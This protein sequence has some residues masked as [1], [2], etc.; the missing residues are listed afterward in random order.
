MPKYQIEVPG[1]G[2]FEV[3]SPTD[4]SDD[5]AYRAVLGQINATPAVKPDTGFTGALKAGKENIL[6]D[7]ERFKGKTGIKDINEAEAAAKAHEV[8]AGQVFKPTEEGWTEA[9]FTKFKETLGGSL[10]YMAAPI[11]AGIGAATLP[12]TGTAATVAGLGLTGLTSAAQFT[13]SNLSRK[14]KEGQ[15]LEEASLLEAGAAAVPQAALDIIGLRMI[16]GIRGIFGKAGIEITEEQAAKLAQRSLL[17]KAGSVALTTGKTMG[18]E[19]LTET[20]QQ[21]LE[22]LQAGLSLTDPQAKQEYY[23][24]FI[25][26]AVLGGALGTAGQAFESKR[27]VPNAPV[28]APQAPP[29]LGQQSFDVEGLQPTPGPQ[30]Q[31][32]AQADP[33]RIAQIRDQYDT[34]ER[35]MDRLRETHATTQD[36]Q[37]KQ[38]VLEDAQKLDFARQE[39]AGQLEGATPR[40]IAPEAQAA[41]DFEQPYPKSRLQAEPTIIGEQAAAPEAQPNLDLE[42]AKQRLAAGAALTP[43]QELMVRQDQAQQRTAL[44]TAPAPN[45]EIPNVVGAGARP[46]SYVVDDAAIDSFGVTKGATKFKN[47]V[48]GLDLMNPED[49]TKFDKLVEQHERKNAKINMD[50]VETFR[51]E[52]PEPVAAREVPEREPLPARPYDARKAF[53]Q[54]RETQFAFGQVGSPLSPR[55][56][57]AQK[58]AEYDERTGSGNIGGRDERSLQLPSTGVPTTEGTTAPAPTGM[59]SPVGVTQQPDGGAAPSGEARPAA[60]AQMV[61]QVAPATKEA[62][63]QTQAKAVIPETVDELLNRVGASKEVSPETEELFRQLGIGKLNRPNLEGG[64][65]INL[66][67]RVTQGD[68]KGALKAITSDKTGQ[69]TPLDKEV[70]NRLLQSKSLPK[71]EVVDPSVIEDGAPAQY[72]PNTDTVQ[73]ARGQVDSHT[74]LHETV[75]GFLH[76]MIKDSEARVAKGFQ[77]NPMLNGLRAIYDAVK[78]N[79]ALAEQYGLKDLSEFI[80]EAFSNPKFQVA[81]SKIPY[82]RMNVFTAFGRA[83]LRALGIPVEG[84]VAQTD[85]LTATLIAAEQVMSHGRNVQTAVGAR[86]NV[87][88]APA[89]KLERLTKLEAAPN[90][91]QKVS[92]SIKAVYNSDKSDAWTKFRVAVIDPAS[93]LGKRLSSLPLFSNGQLRADML[94]HQYAQVNNIVNNGIQSGVPILN[95]DGSVI[96]RETTNNLARSNDIATSLNNNPNVKSWG[97]SGMEYVAE[98]ARIMR[99][100]EIMAEDVERRKVA[101]DAIQTAEKKLKDAKK[102]GVTGAQAIKLNNEAKALQAR[103][104]DDTTINREKQ[105]TPAHIKWAE[106]QLKAVP[107]V[108]DVLNIWKNVNESLIQLRED[109]GLISKELA[110]SLRKNNSYV[111]LFAAEEDLEAMRDPNIAISGTGAKAVSQLHKLK[112]SELTRN[113]WENLYKQYAITTAAVFQNQVRKVGIEQLASLDAAQITQNAKDPNINVRFRDANS[114]YADSN[115]IVNAIVDNPNELAAFQMM[116]YE[117]TPLMKGM[118]GATKMLRAGALINPMYWVKQLIRD[119]LHASIV[120]G[121]VVTPADSIKEYINILKGNSEEAK[122]LARHGAFG[123][124]DSTVDL[125]TFLKGIGTEKTTPSNMD[126]ILHKVMRMHEAS[127]AATRVAIYKKAFADATKKGMSKEEA[128]TY[129]VMKARESANFSVHG[130]S[131]TLNS[132]RQMIPFFSAAVTS[133][134]TVYRAATGYGLNPEEKAKAQRMFYSRAAMMTI[135]TMAYAMLLQGDEDYQKLPD[136]VKDGNWLMPNPMGGGHS[137]I[138]IPVPFEVGFLFK[139]VPEAAVRYLAGNSTGREVLGS[140][141]AGVVQ[142]MPGNGLIIPQL[143]K[144]VLETMTNH[145]FFTGRSIESMSDQN[146]PVSK[147][148]QNA[149]EVAKILSNLGLDKIN[150][151][152]A[153]IDNIIQGYTAQ[154]GTFAVN[155]ADATLIAAGGKSVMDKNIEQMPGFKTFM[156]NPNTSKAV[157]DFYTLQH[158][159]VEVVNEFNKLKK[160]GNREEVLAY[161]ADDRNKK[162]IMAEPALRKIQTQLTAISNQAK[163]IKNNE[164]ID[165]DV[166]LQRVNALMTTYDKVAQQMNKV[167]RAT[168]LE[169]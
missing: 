109:G 48:R 88:I 131:Q 123:A 120:G 61:Q 130:N 140:Y 107:Q 132:I 89:P 138:R 67:D 143:A 93:G 134:D 92:D 54:A 135:M 124:V 63:P 81:L 105:V 115:G 82:K 4:L 37:E 73:I 39:L 5:Q 156:T 75:H 22:R 165:P 58:R 151:S 154:L 166:R 150:L 55:D 162:L 3:D 28:P 1:Q 16:P 43:A 102:K 40:A 168:Q 98:I 31:T 94:H 152:P 167:L 84:N 33:Q 78:N 99:G 34:I 52:K 119:P 20:G 15:S 87:G 9:P 68:I 60:L 122:I 159:A 24:S 153:K 57:R 149:S 36:P 101:I 47:A 164:K 41:L 30:A 117:L 110:D 12:L 83:V 111:P 160:S 96:I 13:G 136:D 42:F 103:Y 106:D 141:G 145:S 129:A 95:A 18:A 116:H 10:P 62:I 27:V 155:A 50:A 112:G 65:T 158:E 8:K 11:A 7:Y 64:S 133:L 32:P 70:A 144:P 163:L 100:K 147:R 59:G 86:S 104:K 161:L 76:V 114:P 91:S 51:S 44:Q 121:Y 29:P 74:V 142:N 146:L 137:F 127:D 35:E 90:V 21:V 128:T 108:Q 17:E 113:I 85:A 71:I 6:A 148:G 2:T 23:D 53:Q 66:V 118:A 14:V 169:R 25:G 80:S 72:N 38:R 69:F 157:G 97:G 19:G 79:P 45:I 56:V 126:K 139:T 125:Q 26:G 46:T 77:P 49:A